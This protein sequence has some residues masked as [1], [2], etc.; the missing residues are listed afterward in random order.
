MFR[1]NDISQSQFTQDGYGAVKISPHATFSAFASGG[2]GLTQVFASVVFCLGVLTFGGV[3][4]YP[5][6]STVRVS[7]KGEENGNNANSLRAPSLPSVLPSVLPSYGKEHREKC[8]SSLL[9]DFHINEP[10][11]HS[12]SPYRRS[13][14][15]CHLRMVHSP[16]PWSANFHVK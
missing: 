7:T 2:R 14:Q 15:N 10:L 16:A 4:I 9:T 13:G 8:H 3:S 5:L 11:I 12:T 6:F 1:R